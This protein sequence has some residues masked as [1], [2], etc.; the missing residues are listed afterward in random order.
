MK[1][2]R[3]G[4]RPSWLREIVGQ[5]WAH[6]AGSEREAAVRFARLAGRLEE[7]GASPQV[8]ALARQAATDEHRHEALCRKAAAAFGHDLEAAGPAVAAEIAPPGLA[9]RERVLYEVLAFCC[10]A[11]TMNAA[12][13]TVSLQHCRDVEMR[14]LCREIL[15]DEVQHSRLGWAHLAWERGRGDLGA[16]AAWL[17]PMLEGAAGDELGKTAEPAPD[18]ALLLALGVLPRTMRLELVRATLRDVIF[19]GLE[20]HGIPTAGVSDWLANI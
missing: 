9:L 16:S 17:R 1:P 18:P 2:R 13:L 4:T 10:I 7:I 15:E 3:A 6:R 14:E 12:L 11:E 19:P 20:A 5:V 8:I